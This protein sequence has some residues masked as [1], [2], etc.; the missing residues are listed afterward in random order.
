VPEVRVFWGAYAPGMKLADLHVHTD[1]SDGTRTVGQSLRAAVAR[2]LSGVAFADHDTVA[3]GHEARELCARHGLPLEVIPC[4]EISTRT[5]HLLGFDLADDVR[6]GLSVGA[7]VEAILRQGGWVGVPHPG[8]GLTDSVPFPEI[9]ALARSGLPVAIEVFNA[10]SRDVRAVAWWRGLP[11]PN[12]AARRFYEEHRE[13]LGPALGGT[14]AHY[15]TIGRGLVA[16]DGGLRE[17]LRRKRTGAALPVGPGRAPAAAA[18]ARGAAGGTGRR[19][20]CA[21]VRTGHLTEQGA[22]RR[23][24]QG[25]A[26]RVGVARRPA[27][28]TASAP[29][30]MATAITTAIVRTP[31]QSAPRP[32]SSVGPSAPR[33]PSTP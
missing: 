28:R 4:S 29:A 23:R 32:T 31:S 12:E 3:T 18:A 14:D 13:L 8:S 22:I 27:A 20:G 11:D 10:G 9:V 5:G 2:G 17:A 26:A 15:R 1:R 16:Y 24:P 33:L 19:G 25:R 6:P 7:T 30:T 21:L